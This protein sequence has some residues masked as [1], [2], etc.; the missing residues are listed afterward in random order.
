MPSRKFKNRKVKIAIAIGLGIICAF[1]LLVF[2][3]FKDFYRNIFTQEKSS[4]VP[5]KIPE[6]K[7]VFTVLLLG[8]AG[9][10]HQ[11]AYLTDSIMLVRVDIKNKRTFLLSLPRDLW[12]KIPTESGALFHSKVNAA[13]Q[14]GQFWE[15][16]PD[17]AKKFRGEQAGADMMKQLVTEVTGQPIDYYVAVDFEGFTKAVEILGG[18]DIAVERSF[19][20]EQ[21]PID[22]REEDLCGVDKQDKSKLEELEKVATQTPH[23]A[24]P[25]R[26][27]KLHFDA[28][29]QLMDGQRAL[30][31][32]RSRYS[33]QEGGDF[34]RGRR[35]QLFLQA[36]K[37]KVLTI[38][39]IPKIIPLLRELEEHV[40]T[41]VP[42]EITQK[43][44]KEAYRGGEYQTRSLVLSTDN[45]LENGYSDRSGFILTSVDGIDRWTSVRRAVAAAIAGTPITPIPQ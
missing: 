23:L 11:G 6:E 9:G 39:F 45:F 40:R 16:Y 30:K 33:P 43:F 37:E 34:S 12:V 17:L 29:E 24:Y 4:V 27:E 19:D 3:E 28:G 10:R 2:V 21:Y 13:Y 15:D 35:Q 1:L 42:L 36:V 7:K 22:G 31:Y 26:Y 32:V 18:V 14:M 5:T 41:D 20:D 25:C 8:Y 44:V 38:G